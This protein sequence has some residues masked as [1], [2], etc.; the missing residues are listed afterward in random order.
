MNFGG[1]QNLFIHILCMS[2]FSEGN[3]TAV[4]ILFS[5]LEDFLPKTNLE[6]YNYIINSTKSCSA[7]SH[8]M[9]IY[10]GTQ[11]DQYHR[12]FLVKSSPM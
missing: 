7:W 10:T 11:P 8:C 6:M 3:V 12:L 1:N 5:N 2:Q 4:N 9:L